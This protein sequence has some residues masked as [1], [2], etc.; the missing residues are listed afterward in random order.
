MAARTRPSPGFSLIELLVVLGIAAII[1]AVAYP[2]YTEHVRRA[3]RAIAAGCLHE[4]AQ[5][6]ERHYTTTMSYAT[7]SLPALACRSDA[8]DRYDFRFAGG[9]PTDTTYALEAVPRNAQA[10]DTGCATLGLNHLGARSR[11]GSA[12]VQS[13]WR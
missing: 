6:M 2:A 10:A 3:H 12:D 5:H 11:S 1:A 4:L 9:Q 7:A 8:A 13:C